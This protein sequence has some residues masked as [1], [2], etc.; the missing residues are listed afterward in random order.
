MKTIKSKMLMLLFIF[1]TGLTKAQDYSVKSYGISITKLTDKA[2]Q[3]INAAPG[4]E[5]T[6][7]V[8]E[9][10]CSQE[11][12]EKVCKTM[13]WITK[14]QIA[15]GS[16]LIKDISPVA[17]LKNLVSL[18]IYMLE[19]SRETPISLE[20]IGKLT[21]LEWLSLY[22]T[23]VTNSEKLTT[24][25][26]LTNLSLYMSNVSSIEFLKQLP[27]LEELDLY[28]A[29]HT[30]PNY[31][32]LSGLKLLT[33]LNIYM[34]T[35]AKDELLSPILNLTALE[36]IEMENCGEITNFDFL[37]NA[38]NMR[39]ISAQWSG[40][41]SIDALA[42]LTKLEELYI[43]DTYITNVNAL[44]NKT[45]LTQLKIQKIKLEDVS[46]LF[47]CTALSKINVTNA[48]T[49]KQIEELK[50]KLPDLEVEVAEE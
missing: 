17:N 40:I 37:K 5:K 9:R 29:G 19:H 41:K 32:P 42:G 26:K 10:M 21:N 30:F 44:K 6:T 45:A 47:T 7:V 13:T 50:A 25:K 24:L 49:E 43:D 39:K 1:I 11:D 3:D 27:Q 36:E 35:Q 20:P 48:I 28:G 31:E 18:N 34:N 22:G 12:F 23:S 33:K 15:G 2:I 46:P 16:E 14:F 38:K 8:L 4:K